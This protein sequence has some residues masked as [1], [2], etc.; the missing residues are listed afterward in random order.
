MSYD[1]DRRWLDKHGLRMTLTDD[2]VH[3]VR[4]V[5]G[6][7]LGEATSYIGAV[8]RARL[9]CEGV[10]DPS[11]D[12]C[13]GWTHTVPDNDKR[14]APVRSGNSIRAGARHRRR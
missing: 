12:C 5:S 6:E 4:T 7:V 3:A 11:F 2:G 1:S 14:P 8:R 13:P 10:A 9:R